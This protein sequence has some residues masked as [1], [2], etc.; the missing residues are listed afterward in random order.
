MKLAIALF[1]D[2]G[3]E[4]DRCQI[5]VRPDQDENAVIGNAVISCVED[6]TLSPGD[7]IRIQTVED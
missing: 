2:H 6:W 4:L 7:T 5:E 1:G 3:G